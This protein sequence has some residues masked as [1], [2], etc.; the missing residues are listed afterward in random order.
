[1]MHT[2]APINETFIAFALDFKNWKFGN[3][4]MTWAI[5]LHCGC[6]AVLA[7]LWVVGDMHWLAPVFLG[8]VLAATWVATAIQ[9]RTKQMRAWRAWAEFLVSP[10][11]SHDPDAPDTYNGPYVKVYTDPADPSSLAGVTGPG[12]DT[13]MWM[14]KSSPASFFVHEAHRRLNMAW[15]LGQQSQRP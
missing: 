12:F 8:F 14:P 6:V 1:M 7:Y 13:P 4:G 11:G 5:V 9:W 2:N 15:K 3:N 10:V